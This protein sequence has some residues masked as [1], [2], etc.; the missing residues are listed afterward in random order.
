MSKK[1]L[2]EKLLVGFS[3]MAAAFML[4]GSYETVTYACEAVIAEEGN[5]NEGIVPYSDIIE[6]RYKVV[7]GDV[8]RRLYNYSKECWVGEWELCAEGLD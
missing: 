4:I 8:Y 7:D 3:A 6:Y 5:E 2:R 1:L